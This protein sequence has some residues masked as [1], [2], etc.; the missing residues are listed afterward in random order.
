MALVH[1]A[2]VSIGPDIGSSYEFP[3]CLALASTSL[4]DHDALASRL[5]PY[6]RE[7]AGLFDLRF[8]R[9][10]PRA[11]ELL[12]RRFIE[13]SWGVDARSATGRSCQ[14]HSGAGAS[15]TLRSRISQP[16]RVIASIRCRFALRPTH[17]PTMC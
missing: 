10:V 1:E 16:C 15:T 4:V 8:L 9:A 17:C 11:R 14:R 5:L 7:R 6:M 2:L 13:E 3:G 12:E